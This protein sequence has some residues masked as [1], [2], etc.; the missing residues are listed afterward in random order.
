MRV[1]ETVQLDELQLRFLV[2]DSHSTSIFCIGIACG[3]RDQT[4][5]PIGLAHLCE[6]LILHPPQQSALVNKLKRFNGQFH[7]FTSD[8][9]TVFSVHCQTTHFTDILTDFCSFFLPTELNW[10][11]LET[12][13]EA[14]EQEFIRNQNDDGRRLMELQRTLRPDGIRAFNCGSKASLNS[15][16]RIQL[17]RN[18]MEYT[19]KLLFHSPVCIDIELGVGQ[20]A[21]QLA[22]IKRLTQSILSEFAASRKRQRK[23]WLQSSLIPY[24]ASVNSPSNCHADGTTKAA[25]TH[26]KAEL[27]LVQ[28]PGKYHQL[29]INCRLPV[30]VTA[31][32]VVCGNGNSSQF[33]L[34]EILSSL[35]AQEHRDGFL[36]QGREAGW[37]ADVRVHVGNQQNHAQDINLCFNGYQLGKERIGQ[38]ISYTLCY[39]SQLLDAVADDAWL[40]DLLQHQTFLAN[41]V[42]F[43]AGSEAKPELLANRRRE[44]LLERLL[45]QQADT[46]LINHEHHQPFDQKT[47]HAQVAC[48]L[49]AVLRALLSGNFLLFQVAPSAACQHKTEGYGVGYATTSINRPPNDALSVHRVNNV[50]GFN[51]HRHHHPHA[52]PAH[53]PKPVSI[54]AH[55]MELELSVLH[56]YSQEL[57]RDQ[58]SVLFAMHYPVT[59]TN[60]ISK[61]VLPVAMQALQ[62]ELNR[63]LWY[64]QQCHS[65]FMVYAHQS[66]FS[67][68]LCAHQSLFLDHCLKLIRC[69]GDA[70]LSEFAMARAI[71]SQQRQWRLLTSSPSPTSDIHTIQCQLNPNQISASVALEELSKITPDAIRRYVNLLFQSDK[72]FDVVYVGHLE[73]I[74]KQMIQQQLLLTIHRPLE[75]TISQLLQ[76]RERVARRLLVNTVVFRQSSEDSDSLSC[77]LQTTSAG[78]LDRAIILLLERLFSLANNIRNND[79]RGLSDEP[80]ISIGLLPIN[81]LYGIFMHCKQGTTEVA[82]LRAVAEVY[83]HALALLR[84]DDAEQLIEQLVHGFRHQLQQSPHNHIDRAQRVWDELN[85]KEHSQY[86]AQLL[87]S[88]QGITAALL[89]VRLLNNLSHDSAQHSHRALW[90][91]PQP[92]DATFDPLA[93]FGTLSDLPCRPEH[94]ADNHL[95]AYTELDTMVLS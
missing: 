72:K 71:H 14:I 29:V 59:P 21:H 60:L 12:E 53:R 51:P 66:G 1:H 44:A 13:I 49:S 42:R 43:G 77:Y 52:A 54:P 84:A 46:P 8:E 75:S 45:Q 40:S 2:D 18:A 92:N 28:M 41:A 9:H 30:N 5:T 65:R 38:L 74:A 47:Q 23:Q 95:L 3:Y 4:E 93:Q 39:C 85:E 94:L 56:S 83:N 70:S 16:P 22:S 27:T 69:I 63:T 61:V 76:Q 48:A 81:Q 20:Y 35:F 17:Q 26:H 15:I 24:P 6:H 67:I 62:I 55:P 58:V 91:L 32:N 33:S 64:F 50:C 90:L 19:R 87:S 10:N 31:F 57:D 73:P 80:S 25:K 79:Q 7:G 78:L 68:R 37:F 34:A 89:R 11:A 86:R 88:M 82:R 36:D